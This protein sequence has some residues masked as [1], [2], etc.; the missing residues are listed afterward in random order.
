MKVF[1][2]DY[3]GVIINIEP[4]KAEA[5]G[6]LLHEEWNINKEN[7]AKFWID[8]GGKSRKYKF[9]YFYE[10]QF[11]KKLQDKD[12]KIIESK[13]SNILKTEFYPKLKLL[14]GASTL[15]QYARSH[16]DYTFVS[17]G[18]PMQEIKR[19]VNLNGV[20]K[21]FDKILGTN[22]KYPSKRE[23]FQEIV[24][25]KKPSKLV[26]VADGTEDMRVAKEFGVIAIGI[27]TNHSEKELLDAGAQYTCNLS[28][29][30][31]TIQA[32]I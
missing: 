15:L 17:S 24:S 3:D 7:A 2:T 6:A 9:D 22:E 8:T 27:L 18:V 1:G 4:K 32:L 10:K 28:Q 30:V 13:Y 21:Y 19:L 16:F 14:P 31:P 12:Y 5:F 25:I 29:V 26:F 11:G 20:T 23:H